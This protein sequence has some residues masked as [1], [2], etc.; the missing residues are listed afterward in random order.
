[1]R[2]TIKIL[3]MTTT[4][5]Y[6]LMVKKR[7]RL[8]KYDIFWKFSRWEQSE[9]NYTALCLSILVVVVV[10]DVVVC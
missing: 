10:H 5:K 9:S 4:T 7:A 2:R 3:L 1:M 6:H 8:G